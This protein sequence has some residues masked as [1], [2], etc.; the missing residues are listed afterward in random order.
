MVVGVH[1]PSADYCSVY[2]TRPAVQ[3]RYGRYG[4][5]YCQ[6]QLLYTSMAG[7]YA[8][9]HVECYSTGGIN[10]KQYL[11]IQQRVYL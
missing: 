9:F 5:V 2:G 10:G 4:S 8:L 6:F 3:W 1:I 11:Y 7:T